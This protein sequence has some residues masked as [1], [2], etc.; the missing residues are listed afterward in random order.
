MGMGRI[1]AQ[2]GGLANRTMR[3]LAMGSPPPTQRDPETSSS[4]WNGRL[5]RGL[6][7][8]GPSCRWFR[9][10][11]TGSLLWMGKTPI[12]R[13]LVAS[14]VLFGNL[15]L[16]VPAA[17]AAVRALPAG[18]TETPVA[19]GMTSPTAMAFAPDGRLFV[20][21]QGGAL[22]VIK[23]G[24]LL[25]TPFVTL[26]VELSRRARPA[27]RRLR[28][29]LRDQPL[30]VR[31]LHGDVAPRSTTAS[32]A[33]P[34]TANVVVAGSEVVHPGPAKRSRATNHNGGA[35]HFGPDGKLYVAVGENADGANAQSLANPLGK[36]LRINRDGSIPTDNPFYGSTSGINRVDLG[37]AACATRS[38]SRSSPSTG[39]MFINDVGQS[40]W[41]EINDGIAGSNY[42]WPISEGPTTTAAV[43]PALRVRA[44]RGPL[45]GCA[46]TGGA[47]YNPVVPQFPASYI[48]S[49]FFA[50]LCGNAIYRIEPANGYA[51]S[52]FATGLDR[53]SICR[54]GL[55]A[56]C[57]TSPAEEEASWAGSPTR[58]ARPRRWIPPSLPSTPYGCWTAGS[59]PGCRAP[60]RSASRGPGR[61]RASPG[62][63]PMRWQ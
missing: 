63:R 12:R 28:S 33:S 35:I 49:Y 56:T 14:L 41:E 34:P 30:R 10:R 7:H 38:P 21:Q 15:V 6:G 46:I 47:F 42:G 19:S 60:L 27:G 2:C 9:S 54:S 4:R 16:T 1:V 3:Y 43:R 13:S 53:R 62:C 31:L 51:L 58:R 26:T 8:V 57:T 20:A 52:T 23:N 17:Q 37:A 32:A 45:G 40:T 18:F 55:T 48:G 50:D 61:W 24:S 39:R 59:G 29:G 22:R 5:A 36:M 44:R 11:P 25:A